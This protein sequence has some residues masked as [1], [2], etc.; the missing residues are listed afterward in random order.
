MKQETNREVWIGIA[1]LRPKPGNSIFNGAPGAFSNA[2]C[3]ARNEVEYRCRVADTFGELGFEVKD[4]TD[5]EP[6]EKRLVDAEILELASQLSASSP[7][8]YDAFYVYES[9]GD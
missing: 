8:L 3:L 4:L 6:L 7:V 9:E 5:I 2:L 1:D